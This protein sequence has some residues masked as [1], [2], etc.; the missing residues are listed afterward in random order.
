MY[1]R[2]VIPFQHRNDLVV[3]DCNCE[4][5][6][7]E[8]D[9]DI[10]AKNKNK[11][12][13]LWQPFKYKEMYITC[14]FINVITKNR[15]TRDKQESATLIDDIFTNSFA[16]PDKTFQCLIYTDLIDQFPTAHVDYLLIW[17]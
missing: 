5:I 8:T 17:I 3:P 6:F 15:P 16:S 2:Y 13:K 11:F 9:W 14:Q 7:I 4:C 1:L 12:I 10:F